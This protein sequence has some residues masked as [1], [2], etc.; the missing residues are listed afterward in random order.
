MARIFLLLAS[1]ALFLLILLEVGARVFDPDGISYFPN[2]AAYMDTMIIEEPLGY[3]NRSN[4][5]GKYYGQ[6]VTINSLGLRHA[7]IKAEPD[8]SRYRILMLGDSSVFGVGVSDEDTLPNQLEALLK[9][10]LGTIQDRPIEVINMGVI[11]YNSEQELIQFETLGARFQPDLVLLMFATNDI[12]P[13]MWI[14][15]RRANPL[16][17][18]GQK[19]Y[20]V[21]LLFSLLRKLR[22]RS[23]GTDTRIQVSS[24]APDNARWQSIDSA[25]TRLNQ[26]NKANSTPF[27]VFT[28]ARGPSLPLLQELSIREDFPFVGLFPFEDPRWAH[29]DPLSLWA[30]GG[31][32]HF[33][34]EGLEILSQVTYEALAREGVLGPGVENAGP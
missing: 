16:V 27:L 5:N 7:E 2:T 29:I 17:R 15:D 32:G 26:L 4:L 19:S 9:E 13:K 21:S 3:R 6:Q 22:E 28:R 8:P 30:K 25:L 14:F 23:S 34:P 12:E 24:Y 33:G 31:G 18:W 11:S 10:E 1:Q 20:A